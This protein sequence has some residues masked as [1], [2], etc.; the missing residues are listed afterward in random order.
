MFA[1]LQVIILNLVSLK[2]GES[3]SHDKNL[4]RFNLAVGLL[5]K[6]QIYGGCR[7]FLI[8]NNIFLTARPV[9]AHKLLH[10]W[11]GERATIPEANRTK[12]ISTSESECK[13]IF[14]FIKI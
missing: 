10:F 14:S 6:C 12:L 11:Q 2:N 1:T 9:G 13:I 3:R 5:A 4:N 8:S 7:T